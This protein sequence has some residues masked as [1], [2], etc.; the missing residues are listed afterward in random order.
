MDILPSSMLLLRVVTRSD[1]PG[2]HNLGK[3]TKGR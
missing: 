1:C 3:I 2:G